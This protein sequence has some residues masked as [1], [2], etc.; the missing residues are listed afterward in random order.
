MEVHITLDG[1]QF[2]AKGE[3]ATA[4]NLYA[5]FLTWINAQAEGK[6]DAVTLEELTARL[7]AN[8]DALAAVVAAHTQGEN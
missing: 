2:E 4:D 6:S 1:N 7:K 5:L 8:S 3:D